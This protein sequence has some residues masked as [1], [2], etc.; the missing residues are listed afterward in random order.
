M[1]L[2]YDGNGTLKTK[3]PLCLWGDYSKLARS[4]APGESTVEDFDVKC[5]SFCKTNHRR[6]GKLPSW[7]LIAFDHWAMYDLNT[8]WRTSL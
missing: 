5:P 2:V 8:P 6:G 7:R 4:Q 1:K 3:C